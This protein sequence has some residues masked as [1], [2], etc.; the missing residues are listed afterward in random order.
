M[1]DEKKLTHRRRREV[2]GAAGSIYWMFEVPER[3]AWW[4]GEGFI[5]GRHD[6]EKGS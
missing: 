5:K 6:E 2:G 4:G 1:C 3:S